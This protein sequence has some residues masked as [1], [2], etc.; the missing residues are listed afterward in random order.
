[1]DFMWGSP[2]QRDT[3]YLFPRSTR[4]RNTW[5]FVFLTCDVF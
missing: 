1:V 4:S 3:W 5:S 2:R